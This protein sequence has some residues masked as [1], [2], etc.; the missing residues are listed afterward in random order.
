MT[1]SSDCQPSRDDSGVIAFSNRARRLALFPFR[2][3]LLSTMTR[4]DSGLTTLRFEL[5]LRHELPPP[6]ICAAIRKSAGVSLRRMGEA[7]DVSAQTIL[8]WEIAAKKP[9][10]RHLPNY[11]AALRLLQEEIEGRAA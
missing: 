10:L 9:S 4:C 8:N 3:N 6:A 7:V 1:L 11:V 5:A 2:A